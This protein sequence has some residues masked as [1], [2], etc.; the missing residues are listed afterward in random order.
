MIL[1]LFRRGAD[2]VVVDARAGDSRALAAIHST[3]FERGWDTTEFEHL[4][5]DRAV[6]CHAARPGGNGHPV[7]FAMSR[8]V[9]DEAEILTVAVVTPWR[10]RGVAKSLMT[11]H[12]G[13]LAGRGVKTLFLE[14]AED[15]IAA[16]RLYRAFGFD[17]VGRRA[18]YYTRRGRPPATALIMRRPLG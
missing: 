9:V 7:G 12:L 13:R 4:L 3:G 10:G 11:T 2:P 18:A 5:A 8:Q 15:N 17:E 1:S 6:I 14:V 16:L